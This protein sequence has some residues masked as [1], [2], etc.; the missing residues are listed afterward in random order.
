MGKALSD[1][2]AMF[3]SLS[4]PF[5]LCSSYLRAADTMGLNYSFFDYEKALDKYVPLGKIGKKI[6]SHIFVQSVYHKLN[7][8]FV[9]NVKE[10]QPD[11][12]FFFT[13]APVSSGALIFIRS[14]LPNCR[15]ILI[16]PDSLLNFQP[17]TY[18]NLSL[19]DGVASYSSS[20]LP[21]MKRISNTKTI[22][23]PLAGDLHLHGM[24][25]ITNMSVDIGFVG[26]WRPE[27]QKRLEKLLEAFPNC[28]FEIHG[29]L[30]KDNCGR[31]ILKSKIKSSG[32]HGPAMA[33]FFNSTLLNLN[34]IDDT[35]YPAANMRFFE[36]MA[37]GGLELVSSC[38]E[39]ESYFEDGKDLLFFHSDVEMIEKARI[40][41]DHQEDMQA[42][43]WNGYNKTRTTHH[44][45]TRL[46]TLLDNFL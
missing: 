15:L 39:M 3:F 28:R 21:V 4:D 42:I 33:R 13:N 20:F 32:L 31:S 27:R 25:P 6:V 17:G 36:I 8:E 46:Q 10:Y 41:M 34:I 7:R 23:V 12:I 22:F 35:N 24:E 38:P 19:F 5:G 2:K 40:A 29:V 16:W 1:T 43:K 18:D 9:V 14:I 44:Y 26:G 37:A 30:W 45:G 11:I